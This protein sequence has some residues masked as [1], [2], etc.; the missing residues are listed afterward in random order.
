MEKGTYKGIVCREEYYNTSSVQGCCGLDHVGLFPVNLL[1]YNTGILLL[2]AL[3]TTALLVAVVQ[4]SS[5]VTP[6]VSTREGV[7]TLTH[8]QGLSYA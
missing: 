2:A 7:L 3:A 1:C 8:Q 4:L 6:Y 5:I